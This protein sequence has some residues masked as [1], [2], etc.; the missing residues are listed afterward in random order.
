MMTP[1]TNVLVRSLVADNPDQTERAV[2]ELEGAALVVLTIPTLCELCWVLRSRYSY[3]TA[4]I[5]EAIEAIVSANNVRV[6]DEAVE[7]GLTMLA[8]GGDFADGVIAYL[9]RRSGGRQF[10]SFDRKAVAMIKNMGG[11]A[12]LPG[13]GDQS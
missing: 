2:R 10:V 4:Q 3:S 1:D 6:D 9:G 7:V 5:S 8:R 13:K 11:E 12:R